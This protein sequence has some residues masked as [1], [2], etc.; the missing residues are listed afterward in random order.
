MSVAHLPPPITSAEFAAV[1]TADES[2]IEKFFGGAW[3]RTLHQFFNQLPSLK[4][5]QDFRRRKLGIRAREAD[6]FGTF[7]TNPGHWYSFHHGG[8]NEAQFNFGLR[9]EYCRFGLGFEFSEKKGG[10]P[11]RVHAVYTCFLHE[12]PTHAASFDAAV[13]QQHFEVEWVARKNVNEL[14]VIPT[15]EVPDWIR[16]LRE[17]PYWIFIGRLLRAGTDDGVL[18]DP[19]RLAEVAANVFATIRPWYESTQLCA[20]S[21]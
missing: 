14:H 15:R 13:R 8:R 10:D 5:L 6:A 1:E 12:V 16:N 11:F 18:G 21:I 3:K 19:V 9:R 2:R 4:D 7:A 17:D 20:R